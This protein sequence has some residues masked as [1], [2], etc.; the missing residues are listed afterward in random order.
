VICYA[1]LSLKYLNVA[2]ERHAH[3][4]DSAMTR[5]QP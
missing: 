5:H 3:P 4:H 2:A 1:F